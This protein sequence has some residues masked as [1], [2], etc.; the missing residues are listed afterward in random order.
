LDWLS[1]LALDYWPPVCTQEEKSKTKNLH[2]PDQE[3]I[4]VFSSWRGWYVFLVI[5]LII[6][7][8][9]FRYF[10]QLFS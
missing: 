9:F 8:I 6:E 4:P 2:M 1:D 10:T 3:K 5:F 7:L